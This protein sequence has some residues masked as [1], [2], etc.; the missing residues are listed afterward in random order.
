MYANLVLFFQVKQ[1]KGARVDRQRGPCN[2]C[3]K[4]AV[5][6]RFKGGWGWLGGWA[7]SSDATCSLLVRGGCW[8][9]CAVNSKICL[10]H[11][12]FLLGVLNALHPS[13]GFS[14]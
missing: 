13:N 10:F 3:V 6:P 1:I 4:P 11:A 8:S 14:T 7:G 12:C 9:G 5:S 2:P